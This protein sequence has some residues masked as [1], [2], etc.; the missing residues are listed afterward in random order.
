MPQFSQKWADWVP[1]SQKAPRNELTALTKGVLS[2]L[3]VPHGV[4][5]GDSGSKIS[6][7][8]ALID[9]TNSQISDAWDMT[10]PSEGDNAWEWI[11][12]GSK[13]GRLIEAEEDRVNAIGSRGDS[14]RLQAACEAW[15]NAWREGIEAWKRTAH[16]KKEA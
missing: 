11:L 9:Q 16:S 8:K 1:G 14:A 5:F 3:S 4:V 15:V 12:R 7:G 13:H 6:A 10:E 2:V